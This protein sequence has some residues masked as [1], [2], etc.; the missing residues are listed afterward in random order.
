[1]YARGAGSDLTINSPISNIEILGLVAED[2]L[3]LTNPG[4]MSIGKV[5]VVTGGDLTMQIGGSLLLDGRVRLDAIV[6]PGANVESGVNLTLNVRGDFTNNSATE[7]SRLAITNRDRIGTGGN[8]AA[9]VGGNLTAMND[10][11]LVVQNSNAQIDN[12]GNISLRTDG[13]NVAGAL[14]AT[15][16]NTGGLIYSDTSLTIASSGALSVQGRRNIPNLEQ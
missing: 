13:I 5:D 7:S 16:D 4:T 11:E 14:G 15:L 8:I 2:S 6:L 1:M 3:H 12:G 10:F 9:N